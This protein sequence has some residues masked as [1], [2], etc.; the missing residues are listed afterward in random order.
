[1]SLRLRTADPKLF[2]HERNANAG[3]EFSKSAEINVHCF[4]DPGSGAG[5]TGESVKIATLLA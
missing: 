1:M 4:F 5:R 2:A 3:P